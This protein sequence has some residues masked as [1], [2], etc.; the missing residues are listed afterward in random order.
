M[1]P[2]APIA[3]S[4]LLFGLRAPVDR[5]AYAATGFSLITLKYGLDAGLIYATTGKALSPLLYL[6]PILS[7]KQ[8]IL[9]VAPVWLAPTLL[10][11][12]LPFAWI[13]ASMSLRRA[14]DAG[15]H[16]LVGLLFFAP[17][18]NYLTMFA[19]SVLPSRPHTPTP[20]GPLGGSSRA[21]AAALVGVL[22]G[23]AL[24]G[25]LVAFSTL[26]LEG[27][28]AGLFLGAPFLMGGLAG[29]LFNLR[30]TRPLAANLGLSAIT[31][32]TG[33]GLCLLFALD[34]L[35]CISMASPLFFVASLLGVLLGRE[36]ARAE[37]SRGLLVQGAILPLLMWAEP[38]PGPQVL[39]EVSTSVEIAASPEEMWDLVIA[40][41]PIPKEDLPAWY[42][43]L[44][45]AW[46][47]SARIEG[48][49]V[50][51]VRY[52]QLSTGAFVEPIT[53]WEPG[54]RLAFDVVENPPTMTELSPWSAVAAPHLDNQILR[55]ARGEFLLEP[56]PDGRTR[57]TGTTWYH[58]DM[59]PTWYWTLISDPILH[60][61]H[62]RVLGHIRR[63]AEQ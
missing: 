49:G 42:F 55:S 25:L 24:L 17:L 10:L 19:L 31:T 11:L 58:F 20:R 21:F 48:S 32:A 23:G 57:L 34:G 18:L 3:P 15:L 47:Q 36:L 12:S 51:A 26:A 39:H 22:G 52:C 43:Q 41:P 16:P 2:P 4:A 45:V 53:I 50:G 7:L 28:G 38:P 6:T 9:S 37:A 35:I 33:L 63:V 29:L 30:E 46:P 60:A 54:R 56:L 8:D 27:Y 14:R 1:E 62:L 40:F 59:A 13:G 5:K 61:I 44:G